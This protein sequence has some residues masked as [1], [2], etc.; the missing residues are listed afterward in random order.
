MQAMTAAD[1]LA[2]LL[3]QE[4]RLPARRL[5]EAT[6]FVPRRAMSQSEI[7]QRIARDSAEHA[8]WLADAMTDL[9]GVS[10]PYADDATT[11]DMHFQDITFVLPRLRVALEDLVSVY[12]RAAAFVGDEPHAAE[13]VARIL[14]RHRTHLSELPS[15]IESEN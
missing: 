14:T 11:A 10:I 7:V 4:Q 3:V 2:E 15:S 13:T 9:G 1:V 12:N 8:V 6:L 5:L